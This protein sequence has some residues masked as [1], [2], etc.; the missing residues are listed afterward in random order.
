MGGCRH[1]GKEINLVEIS[2]PV[3]SHIPPLFI[4]RKDSL[5]KLGL[6]MLLGPNSLRIEGVTGVAVNDF[7]PFIESIDL[8]QSDTEWGLLLFEEFDGLEGLL[9]E[10]VHDVDDE[11]GQIAEG[12]TSGSEV[13]E[14]LVTGGV[15]NKEAGK[16][17][18]DVFTGANAIAVL[19]QVL[20]REVGRSDLLG[21]S[22]S[23]ASLHIRVPQL[24]KNL[25]FSSIDVPKNTNDRASQLLRFSFSIGTLCPRSQKTGLLLG[26]C[27]FHRLA[28]NIGPTCCHFFFFLGF[29]LCLFRFGLGSIIINHLEVFLLASG[30]LFIFTDWHLVSQ[31]L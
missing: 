9:L 12:R 30:T 1:E 7:F 25:G 10:T 11:D 19:L 8:V 15:D 22:T 29:F 13:G 5:I 21:N 31:F 18:F 16:F 6:E 2:I 27:F 4:E 3:A 20:G 17:E 28:E 24:V 26:H 14:R 23:F